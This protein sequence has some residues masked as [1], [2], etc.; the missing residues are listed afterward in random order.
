M[1]GQCSVPDAATVT[2][3]LSG[4]TES[5]FL[6]SSLPPSLLLLSFW[7][8]FGE[9]NRLLLYIQVCTQTLIILGE[10]MGCWLGCAQCYLSK[11]LYAFYLSFRMC[12]S[13]VTPTSPLQGKV[14]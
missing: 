8:G 14:E 7:E 12:T 13:H 4:N 2:D 3:S 6:P 1:S 11:L 9:R 10:A 5:A